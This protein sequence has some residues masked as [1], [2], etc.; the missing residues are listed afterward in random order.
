[1]GNSGPANLN[2][3]SA[4]SVKR[5]VIRMSPEALVKAEPLIAEATLP[6]LMQP[7]IRGISLAAW[8]ASNRDLIEMQ[9]LKH[10]GILFR[11]FD[12]GEA[13]DFEQFIKNVS[14]ELLE[15]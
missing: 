11:G 15:Y 6:L 2:L 13:P 9:L 3:H 10:G 14:G 7:S 4:G 5:Q 12:V 8:G 1:M